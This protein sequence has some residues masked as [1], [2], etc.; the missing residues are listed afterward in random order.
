[1]SCAPASEQRLDFL[2]AAR[3]IAAL[4]VLVEHGLGVCL[5]A[6]KNWSA[7][8]INLGRVGVILFL[9]VSGFIIP[10]SLE[11][12]GSNARFWL[13]RF[14]RLFPAYWL[15]ILAA[16]AGCLV[17]GRRVGGVALDQT[18][19]W[20][21]NV[22]MLQ[23]FF[24]R[25]HVWGVFWT[26]QLEL[27]I[28]L[29]CSLLFAGRL[30]QRAGWIAG[31]ALVGYG[32]LGISRPLLEGKPFGI[33][34]ERFLYF[35]PLVGFAAQR[36]WAGHWTRR[37]LFSL[38]LGKVLMLLVIWSVN[39][40]C[41][42]A[43]MTTACLWELAIHW[44][45]AYGCFFV[46][47]GGCRWSVPAA[48]TWLGRISYSIYLLHPCVLAILARAHMPPWLFFPILMGGTLVLAELAYRFVEAPG[49]ALGRAIERRCLTRAAQPMSA[50]IP[51]RRAA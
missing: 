17:L 1:M 7:A 33:G 36:F 32:V 23:G 20:F 2:D 38:M 24:H 43:Q 6:Y 5:P 51:V 35:A 45:P 8:H 27:V 28:Y 46:L 9:L 40:M 30:L 31:L 19:D 42:P 15:S 3:A 48:A 22:T 16:L 39:R 34:G 49:I 29:T 44:G 41:L 37:A 18:G 10:V 4:L 13:R 25:P 12:G 21:W 47:I 11:Q 26:L 50:A 14:F